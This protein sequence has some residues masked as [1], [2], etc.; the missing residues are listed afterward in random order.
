MKL[1]FLAFS[2]VIAVSGCATTQIDPSIPQNAS[3]KAD[4]SG[5]NYLDKVVFSFPTPE[6]TEKN[7]GKCIAL[8]VDNDDTALK[9]SSRS[10]VGA[11]TGNYY[12]IEQ[13]SSSRGSDVLRHIDSDTAVVQGRS[14]ADYVFLGLPV[15][16]V[17]DYK[18]LIDSSGPE[19]LL[20]FSNLKR[21]QLD[22]GAASN[23]GFVPIGAWSSAGPTSAIGAIDAIHRDIRNCL[24]R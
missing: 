21:A 20:E 19:T 1:A 4:N 18:L 23:S 12:R 2:A 7:L 15:K 8:Y 5:N 13:R 9:D 16:A 17:I 6:R 22:T 3:L 11:Y 14:P 24:D 10:F